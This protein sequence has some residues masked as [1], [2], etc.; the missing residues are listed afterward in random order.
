MTLSSHLLVPSNDK[1][2]FILALLIMTCGQNDKAFQRIIYEDCEPDL[3]IQNL[4]RE[5]KVDL[6]MALAQKFAN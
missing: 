2:S 3:E 6:Q 4:D 1:L 5:Q